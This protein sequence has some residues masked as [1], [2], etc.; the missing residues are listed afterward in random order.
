[1]WSVRAFQST[2][3]II[4]EGQRGSAMQPV[5]TNAG[6]QTAGPPMTAV[7]ESPRYEVRGRVVVILRRAVM[8]DRD[9]AICRAVWRGARTLREVMSATGI[10]STS[11][12]LRRVTGWCYTRDCRDADFYGPHLHLGRL[13]GTDW[14]R[15]ADGQ[16]GGTIRPGPRFAGL[17]SNQWPLE[18][19]RRSDG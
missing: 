5:S 6:L 13:V 3:P 2:R 7:A 8:D 14:L 1:M 4:D 17:D 15:M 11:T 19:V 12:V 16:R 18:A 9:A 10:S